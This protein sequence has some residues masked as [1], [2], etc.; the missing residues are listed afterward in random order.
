MGALVFH[1]RKNV[2]QISHSSYADLFAWNQW[3]DIQSTFVH[4]MWNRLVS[5][6]VPFL[7]PLE[8]W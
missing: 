1:D 8:V 7:S 3:P 2:S 5:A 4:D 6:G